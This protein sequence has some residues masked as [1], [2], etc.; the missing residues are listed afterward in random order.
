[1]GEIIGFLGY[2]LLGI[3]LAN[4][5]IGNSGHK[6]DEFEE[7]VAL[8]CEI[9]KRFV[10]DDGEEHE[11]G[12]PYELNEK[13]FCCG[14]ELKYEKKKL[15]GRMIF[16][17][18][19]A[20]LAYEELMMDKWNVVKSAKHFEEL[21]CEESMVLKMIL[22]YYDRVSTNPRHQAELMDFLKTHGESQGFLSEEI[23]ES[24]TT[25]A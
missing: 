6:M 19:V 10:D 14:H 24:F 17:M 3:C 11:P 1:M 4:I 5:V 22:Y 18:R 2:I 20:S 16:G 9:R 8:Y 7:L 21:Q 13:N 12:D 15:F 25:Q 23:I